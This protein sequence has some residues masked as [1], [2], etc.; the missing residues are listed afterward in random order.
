MSDVT[1]ELWPCAPM[2]LK[3]ASRAR[4]EEKDEEPSSATIGNGW[5]RSP[6]QSKCKSLDN[7]T[8][9]SAASG[10][11]R[12]CD[13]I[14]VRI[15]RMGCYVRYRYLNLRAHERH[16]DKPVF[17]IHGAARS[18]AGR[19]GTAARV[20]LCTHPPRR[21]RPDGRPR[22]EPRDGRT[23]SGRHHRRSERRTVSASLVCRGAGS[24][25]TGGYDG[26]PNDGR[27]TLIP[28]S[29]ETSA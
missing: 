12:L 11:E 18:V 13:T 21:A 2:A 10:F 6:M 26:H 1:A 16:K 7:L 19:R 27:P 23:G 14:D 20:Q 24:G 4:W 9:D 25:G 28:T 29:C 15:D 17:S 8:S 22:D 5:I 3:V